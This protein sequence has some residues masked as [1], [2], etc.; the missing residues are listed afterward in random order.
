MHVYFLIIGGIFIYSKVDQWKVF[1]ILKNNVVFFIIKEGKSIFILFATQPLSL[2]GW[3]FDNEIWNIFHSRFHVI[4]LKRQNRNL[5]IH[6]RVICVVHFEQTLWHFNQCL[7][8]LQKISKVS[9]PK[10]YS[11]GVWAEK[12]TILHCSNAN[13]LEKKHYG[14]SSSLVLV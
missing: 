6:Y 5:V 7:F 3:H 4:P 1:K 8:V 14:F 2:S 9:Y 13:G 11:K 10:H 12:S